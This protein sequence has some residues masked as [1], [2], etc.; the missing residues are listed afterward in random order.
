MPE[1]RNEIGGSDEVFLHF[2]PR[3]RGS[4]PSHV[5]LSYGERGQGGGTRRGDRAHGGRRRFVQRRDGIE[6]PGRRYAAA[7]GTDAVR[8][9]QQHSRL[10]MRRLLPRPWSRGRPREELV[11]DRLPHP[12]DACREGGGGGPCRIVVAA[13]MRKTSGGSPSVW[14]MGKIPISS[15]GTRG[16]SRAG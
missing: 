13:T 12:Q 1:N 6:R 16:I 14:T 15:T 7:Q 5:V 9:R 2:K 8:A 4:N 11:G 3:N 10:W